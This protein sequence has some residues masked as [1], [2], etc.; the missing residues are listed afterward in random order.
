MIEGMQVERAAPVYKQVADHLRLAIADLRLKPGALLIERELCESIGAS[1]PSIRDALRQLESEGLAVS[2]PGKGTRVAVL[3]ADDARHVYQVRGMLE[4]LAG[5]LFATSASEE[6]RADLC[7]RVEFVEAAADNPNQ[8]L[9]AKN[10]FYAALLR[11]AHNPVAE[12]M[13]SM[14]HRRITLLR[15]TSLARPGRAAKSVQEI[16]RILQAIDAHDGEAAELACREH[17]INAEEAAL[18]SNLKE[19]R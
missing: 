5:Q 18:G 9:Q 19:I 16:K 11:G 6:E 7:C 14:L 13:L 3:S 4:G 1:R 2:M 12:Q 15:A 17:V 10:D 8:L